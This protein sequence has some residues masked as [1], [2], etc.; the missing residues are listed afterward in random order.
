M[1]PEFSQLLNDRKPSIISL[2]DEEIDTGPS[3]GR[4]GVGSNRREVTDR[5]I[6]DESL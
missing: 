1:V 6:G 4:I 3:L 5:S 2:Y